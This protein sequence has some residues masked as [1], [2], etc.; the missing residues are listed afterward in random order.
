MA[1]DK[2]SSV[3]RL[4]GL[5]LAAAAAIAF[6][7]APLSAANAGDEAKV[8]AAFGQLG[9]ACKACHDKYRGD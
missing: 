2:T 5:A 7:A 9:A 4:S 3:K 1:H 6:S 8:K